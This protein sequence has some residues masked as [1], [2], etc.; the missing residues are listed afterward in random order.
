MNFDK[1]KKLLTDQLPHSF[2]GSILAGGAVGSV[3]TNKPIADFDLYF[4]SRA[5][6]EG[7]VV[8]AYDLSWWCL[9]I[10]PRAITF[11]A[12]GVIVQMMSFRFFQTAQEIFESFDY[13][14]C[15][16]AFD[17]DTREMIFHDRF[18]ADC[19]RRELIFNHK[20]DFPVASGLRI[21]KYMERGYTISKIE[22]IKVLIACAFVRPSGWRELAEQLGGSYAESVT[23]DTSKEFTKENAVAAVQVNANHVSSDMP[24]SAEE[25]LKI[26]FGSARAEEVA[27]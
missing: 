5:A 15:M 24:G 2:K 19:S 16:A 22:M 27:A 10:S 3:F 11:S 20:T 25:A 17:I 7:A 18:I 26:I 9:S 21:L 14:C 8:D 6:F 4:K 1:E 23:L 13:T 12:N